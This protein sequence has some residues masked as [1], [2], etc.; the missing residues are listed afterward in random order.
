M[1]ITRGGIRAGASL[2]DIVG[3]R[4]VGL[5]VCGLVFV[6]VRRL[7]LR[8]AGDRRMGRAGRT[9]P[10]SASASACQA[11]ATGPPQQTNKPPTPQKKEKG[12]GGGG[13]PP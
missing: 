8:F 6:H 7:A 4:G 3:D 10:A 1:P 5:W 12:E 11:W 13:L 2:V 9:S